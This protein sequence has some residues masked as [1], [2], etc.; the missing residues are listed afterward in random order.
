MDLQSHY[1]DLHSNSI[2]AVANNDSIHNSEDPINRK[3]KSRGGSRTKK[4][5][6]RPTS[7]NKKHA[8]EENS[9]QSR[10]SLPFDDEIDDD[11][12]SELSIG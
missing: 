11:K 12:L 3:S 2:T 6:A 9:K 7:T 10:S 5:E 8:L 1:G 4:P